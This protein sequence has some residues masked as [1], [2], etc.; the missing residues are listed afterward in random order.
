MMKR[1]S[2]RV[3]RCALRPC[4]ATSSYRPFS[5]HFSLGNRYYCDSAATIANS[6]SQEHNTETDLSGDDQPPAV[7]APNVANDKTHADHQASV[8]FD[9]IWSQLERQFTPSELKFPKELIFLMGAPG[10]GKGTNTSFILH[11]RAMVGDPI[12]ISDLLDS[13]PNAKKLK[14]SG[15]LVDDSY[16]IKVLFKNLL[17][18]EHRSGA[19]I[20]GFPRSKLQCE[21]IKLLYDKMQILK[22]DCPSLDLPRPKFRMIV[23]WVDENTSVQRQLDRAKRIEEENAEK[24]EVGMGEKMKELRTTDLDESKARLRYKT[25][26]EHFDTLVSLR[27]KFPFYLVHARGRVEEVRREIEEQ[28]EYQSKLE[29]DDYVYADIESIPLAEQVTEGARVDLIKRLEDYQY[30]HRE[31]WTKVVKIIREDWTERLYR[32]VMGGQVLVRSEDPVWNEEHA[33]NMAIDIMSERG[34]RIVCDTQLDR[35]P[36]RIEE[37]KIICKVEERRFFHITFPMPVLRAK[38]ARADN[39]LSGS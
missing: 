6:T 8:L 10:S 21:V 39:W 4:Y 16:V 34:F 30:K 26:K 18:P 36:D 28:M 38:Q 35:I 27:E 22:K 5:N 37:G 2:R 32:G 3:S 14:D 1:S 9:A 31:V 15:K 25:F 24:K 20:D 23:L 19:L 7:S 29:L 17:R 13:D 11:H 33:V 12:V